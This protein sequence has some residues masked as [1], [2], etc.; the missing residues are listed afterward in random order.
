MTI[1]Q[2][3]FEDIHQTVRVVLSDDV[4]HHMFQLCDESSSRETGGVLLGSYSDDKSTVEIV[5]AASPPLDSKF[6]RNLFQRG[7]EGLE[8]LLAMRWN[9][10]PRT[11]YVGE[12]HSHTANVPEPS[13][14]DK[15][16]M[17]EITRDRRY[18]CPEP[19]LIIVHPTRQAQYDIRCFI[20]PGDAPMI[21]LRRVD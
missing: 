21:T 6:G 15:T 9:S 13:L 18:R 19:L 4:A 14:Q 7:I 5:E 11:H 2:W 20:F 3:V 8:K 16:Q 17:R 12:W 1:R 10:T